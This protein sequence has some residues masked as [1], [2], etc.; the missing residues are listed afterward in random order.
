MSN[1]ASMKTRPLPL[2]FG[3]LR[4]A[5]GNARVK[6][7]CGDTMEFWVFVKDHAIVDCTFT[8]DGC[9]HSIMVGSA[10]A[11]LIKGLSL[12]KVKN[13]NEQN[14]LAIA[15]DIPEESIHC[16]LLAV[17][18]ISAAIDDYHKRI[19]AVSGKNGPDT[20][21]KSDDE[22]LCAN[23]RPSDKKPQNGAEDGLLLARRM[24]DI[25]HKLVVLSGKGGVGKSTVAVNLAVALAMRGKQ[26]GLLDTDIHGPSIPMMLD[27]T[28]TAAVSDG[29][30][31]LPVPVKGL[32]NLKAVSIGFMLHNPDEAVIWRGPMKMGVIRQFLGN[33]K[34]GALDYLIVDCPPGTGDEPLSVVQL[35]GKS[36]SAVIVT[37]P[38][39]MSAADVRKSV[40]FCRQLNLPIMGVVEN[41]AGFVC[42]GCGRKTDIF[43]AGG[44]ARLAKAFHVPFLGSIPI[45][46]VIGDSCDE[47]TPFVK[48]HPGLSAVDLFAGITDKL[49]RADEGTEK[50]IGRNPD[51]S[52][53]STKE[54]PMKIAVPV[55]DG[56]LTA[57]FGHCGS[58][59]I[60]DADQE[61]RKIIKRQDVSAPPHEPG[62][63]PK[64]LAEQGVNMIIAGGMGQRAQGLF[65]ERKIKVIAGAPSE[66]PEKLV[67][68]F[69]DG[70]LQPG[71]NTCDH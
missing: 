59:A 61:T 62:L 19:A 45:D 8:S 49:I 65:Q 56:R 57:H 38:Q 27:M 26:V 39:E 40:N 43:R 25:R 55:A 7:P 68:A 42:P 70:T 41:M 5:N 50:I 53:S 58:F 69:L 46:P 3:P 33:V 24:T 28:G 63:L 21:G 29:V 60:I 67:G 9:Y 17:K 10:G 54:N 52:L 47:G 18:T 12:D 1:D 30:D 20:G 64:W 35:L 31:I 48:K 4:G 23:G 14:I 15:G 34:W 37:T 44:G 13:I 22:A 2:N 11:G 16:A 66:T 36:A 51:K 32:A 6:G 71:D